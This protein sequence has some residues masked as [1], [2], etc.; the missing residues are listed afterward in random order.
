[1]SRALS[2]TGGREALLH[3]PSVAHDQGLA[4]E[5][6]GPECRKQQRDL[7]YVCLRRELA[8]HGFPQ[9]HVL[10]HFLF[11]DSEF[12]RLLRDLLVDQRRANIPRTDH[13]GEATVLTYLHGDS[14]STT[15]EGH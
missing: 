11:A 1:M 3:K 4:S 15:V 5:G 7:G 2:L 6:I 8:V 14:L 10:D 12:A 13:V 9:H